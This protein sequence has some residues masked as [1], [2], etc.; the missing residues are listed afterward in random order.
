MSE[1]VDMVKYLKNQASTLRY[2]LGAMLGLSHNDE[3]DIYNIYGYPAQLEYSIMR[4]YAGRQGIANL[5]THGVAKSCWRDGFEIYANADEDAEPELVNELTALKKAGLN[6]KLEQADILN[7]IGKFSV[8]FI[9]VPDEQEA[10]QPVGRVS[11][12]NLDKLYF[13][14]FAYD[15]I[16]IHKQVQDT[17][18]PRYGLPE[19]YQVQQTNSSAFEK[20]VQRNAITVHWTRIVHFNEN[21]LESDV[22][23]MGQL[24][25]VFNRI[26]DL[27]KACG[28]SAEAYFRNA[29]GKMAY[30]VDPKFASDLLDDETASAA[31]DEGAKKFTNQQQDFIKLSGASAKVLDTPHASPKDTILAALWEISGYTG[32]RIRILTGQGAGQ[33]AGSEDQLAYNA[34][35]AGRQDLQC[36]GWVV[37][38]LEVLANAGML[39]LP[40]NY[41]IRFPVQ[42]AVTEVEAAGIAS[43]KATTIKSVSEAGSTIG[44]DDLDVEGTLKL[45]GID[46]EISSIGNGVSEDENE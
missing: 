5:I 6:K 30:E 23:G 9:G 35:I 2:A 16:T 44:G 26:L 7:R 32:I 15:G 21:A 39:T 45:L 40:E 22:E 37:N 25:P 36:A 33:H 24:E 3:R 31:F 43:T 29:R 28:G 41:E 4:Q 38:V 13:K 19:L 17:K 20:D 14:A 10:D 8:L 27:D 46:V 11:A 12:S 42:K 1:P 34:L 18:D